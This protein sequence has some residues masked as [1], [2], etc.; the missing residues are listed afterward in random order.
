MSAKIILQCR[1]CGN[2]VT[3]RIEHVRVNLNNTV[4]NVLRKTSENIFSF[5]FEKLQNGGQVNSEKNLK[6]QTKFSSLKQHI[7]HVKFGSAVPTEY[8]IG[9]RTPQYTVRKK[10]NL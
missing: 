4:T 6:N 3:P 1:K 5:V 2:V 7:N 10:K 9:I 8:K